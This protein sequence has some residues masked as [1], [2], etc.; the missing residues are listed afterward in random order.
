MSSSSK[1]LPME[2]FEGALAYQT[3]ADMLH[4]RLPAQPRIGLPL[5]DPVYFLYH[6]AVELALRACLATSNLRTK[7]TEH[8]IVALFEQCRRAKLLGVTDEHSE[9]QELIGLLHGK[10]KGHSYRYYKRARDFVPELPWVQ[11]VVRQLIADVEPHLRTWGKSN[12]VPDP[13]DPNTVTRL[14]FALCKPTYNKQAEP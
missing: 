13:L 8:N 5:S 2:L 11:E 7:E 6:H 1:L 10:D 12:G 3:S 9:M 4:E 14:R